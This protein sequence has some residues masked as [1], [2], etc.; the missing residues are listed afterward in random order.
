MSDSDF[1]PDSY[2]GR[3]SLC[4]LFQQFER[5]EKAIRETYRCAACKAL[6]RER[7][8][9]QAVLNGLSKFA[10]SS[11]EELIEHSGFRRL[12][13][14]HAGAAGR[15]ATVLSGLPRYAS[16]V[17]AHDDAR[18]SGRLPFDDYSALPY[19]DAAFDLVLSCNVLHLVRECAA[20][21]REFA[22]VLKPGGYHV[23]AIPLQE[24]LPP[25]TV[26]RV[27]CSSAA[28]EVY[29]LPRRYNGDGR[30]GRHLVHT[31]FGGDVA[32]VLSVPGLA[33]CM[34]RTLTG[35]KSANRLLTPI[36]R[37]TG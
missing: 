18:A 8:Q 27:D 26:R 32:E 19:G 21:V 16:D 24:P 29:L 3:C 13:V 31:D 15:L 25:A 34:R 17:A 22:R 14:F 6:L 33:V 35:S 37:K 2:F 36:A 5:T 9:A 4:G 28:G 7:E 12:A 30:G 20:A 10:A 11:L 23:A 1:E